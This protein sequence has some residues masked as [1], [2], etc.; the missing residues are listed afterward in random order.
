MWKSPFFCYCKFYFSFS[1]YS[2][3]TGEKVTVSISLNCIF[4]FQKWKLEMTSLTILDALTV[5][6]ILPHQSVP[7]CCVSFEFLLHIYLGQRRQSHRSSFWLAEKV[8]IN[9]SVALFLF[10]QW[11]GHRLAENVWI[12]QS[13]ALFLFGS[14]TVTVKREKL[15]LFN[16]Q[17]V[18]V[19]KTEAEHWRGISVESWLV[20]GYLRLCILA[21]WSSRPLF[22]PIRPVKRLSHG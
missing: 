18:S 16:G 20:D 13:A 17:Y 5:S 6:K 21:G 11:N 19:N 15:P 22:N 3:K 7:H 4:L 1:K 10:W 8:W 12:N 9:Q 14:G 2:F